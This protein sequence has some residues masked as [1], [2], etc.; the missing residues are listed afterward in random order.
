MSPSPRG[1]RFP[2]DILVLV[3]QIATAL[4]AQPDLLPPHSDGRT[5][6]LTAGRT[7]VVAA[8]ER[9]F[10]RDDELTAPRALEAAHHPHWRPGDSGE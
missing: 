10:P 7:A 1:T 4:A 2:V 3:D 5:T 6:F 8:V 9:L